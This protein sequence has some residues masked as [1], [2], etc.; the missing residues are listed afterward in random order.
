[1]R[2]VT[3]NLCDGAKVDAMGNRCIDCQ[4]LGYF[5]HWKKMREIPVIEAEL[6]E[7]RTLLRYA[8]ESAKL[9]RSMPIEERSEEWWIGEEECKETLTYW[10]FHV[11]QLEEELRKALPKSEGRRDGYL[12]D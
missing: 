11:T 5:E 9:H 10:Q 6:A 3:C 12:F 1:M 7:T 2:V 8:E 4:G